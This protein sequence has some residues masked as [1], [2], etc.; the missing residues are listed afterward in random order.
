MSVLALGYLLSEDINRAFITPNDR[1][2]CLVCTYIDVNESMER[3]I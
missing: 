2:L 3:V 1:E